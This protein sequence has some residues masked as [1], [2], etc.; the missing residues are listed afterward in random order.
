MTLKDFCKQHQ[1]DCIE[2]LSSCMGCDYYTCEY[3]GTVHSIPQKVLK[4]WGDY[5][6]KTVHRIKDS[7]FNTFYEIVLTC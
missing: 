3:V 4:Q 5:K 7:P 6:I 1:A 2:V